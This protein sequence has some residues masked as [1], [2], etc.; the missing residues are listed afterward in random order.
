M[1][2]IPLSCTRNCKNKGKYVAIVDD[3][4]FDYL[5]QFKWYVK[6][7]K[8]TCYAKR[9]AVINSNKI[10]ISMHCDIMNDNN[11]DHKDHDGLN[12]QKSNLRFCTK[13]QNSANMKL[14]ENTSSKYKGVIWCK[15]ANKWRSKVG[16]NKTSIHLGYFKFEIEAAKAYD[17]KAKE[18]FG[19]FAYLNFPN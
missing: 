13:Q 14:R 9:N 3:E 2:E 5:N 17:K 6:K 10:H 1:K 8:N 18:L 12:N 7:D 15:W 16:F 19:E 4:D 11:I